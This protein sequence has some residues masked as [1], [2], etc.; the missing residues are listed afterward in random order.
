MRRGSRAPCRARDSVTACWPWGATCMC[1]EDMSSLK[2]LLLPEVIQDIAMLAV[3]WV[4][5]R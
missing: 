3:V 2:I 5:G 4:H 1:S